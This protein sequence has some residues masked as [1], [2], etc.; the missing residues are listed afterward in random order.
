MIV[1]HRREGWVNCVKCGGFDYKR[2]GTQCLRFH[3]KLKYRGYVN[4]FLQTG[5]LWIYVQRS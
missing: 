4:Y 1:G 3:G 2:M 5:Y